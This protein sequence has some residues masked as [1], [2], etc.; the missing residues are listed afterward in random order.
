MPALRN[1]DDLVQRA[2]DRQASKQELEEVASP[3]GPTGT[4]DIPLAVTS[5]RVGD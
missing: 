3:C 4:A 2:K 5:M 1:L